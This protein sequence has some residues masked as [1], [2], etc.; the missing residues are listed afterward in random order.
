[1]NCEN[2]QELISEYIDNLLD[3][4]GTARVKAHLTLCRGCA[5]IYED[6]ASI[7]NV[8]DLE[9]TEEIPPPNQQALW[10]RINNIIESEIKPEAAREIKQEEDNRGWFSR[11]WHR[12]W[13][14]S[15]TQLASAVMGIALISSLLT[16]VGIRN[17]VPSQSLNAAVSKEPTIF[18]RALSKVG[19]A[20]TPQDVRE[21]H[22]R[23]QQ[24]AIDYWNNRVAARRAQWDKNL[25]DAFDRNL[26][27]INQAVGEYSRIL[28]ENPQDEISGEMLNSAMDEKMELLREFSEL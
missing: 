11:I 3:E 20:E 2:C 21:G 18:E 19:L 24:V 16:V 17:L 23:E 6:F 15:L 12:T 1:M 28:Q 13:A 5:E 7:L 25:R 22:L 27:E 9:I 4:K 14:L 10:C 8:Y 26:S